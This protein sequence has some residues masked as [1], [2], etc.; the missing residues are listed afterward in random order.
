MPVNPGKELRQL[1]CGI[2]GL[3]HRLFLLDSLVD[4]KLLKSGV[5]IPIRKFKDG[6]YESDWLIG[7]SL[8]NYE[9]V[10]GIRFEQDFYGS[11]LGEDVIFSVKAKR[12]GKLLVDS[13]VILEHLESEIQ[14]PDKTEF[15]KMWVTNRF[16]LISNQPNPIISKAA[17]VWANLGQQLVLHVTSGKNKESHVAGQFVI[18]RATIRCIFASRKT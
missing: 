7:C 14:R 8:W 17:F 9:K 10:K 15:W 3:F 12:D 13:N 2:I 6:V 11:S 16:R 1:P 5:N 18:I 4:G